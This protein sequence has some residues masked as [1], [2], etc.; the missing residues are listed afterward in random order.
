MKDLFPPL[1]PGVFYH[2]YNRGN[3]DENLFREQRNYAYFL[4]LYARHVEPVAETY[5][6]CLLKNHFHL[7]VRVRGEEEVVSGE[8]KPFRP[9]HNFGNLFNA[10]TKTVNKTYGRRGSLFQR[11]FKRVAVQDDAYLR[12]LIFYIHANPRKHG[13]VDDFRNWPWSSYPALTGKGKTRLAREAV[14]ALFGGLDG[15]L[16]FHREMANLTGL[17]DP[18]GFEARGET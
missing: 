11:R 5:A 12:R 16:E 13:L 9:S 1:V 3:N 14:L 8:G 17:Q 4:Q 2:I 10:Y 15:F 18:L 7:L 6:Y